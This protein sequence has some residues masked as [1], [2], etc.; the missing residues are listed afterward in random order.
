M[1]ISH[2]FNGTNVHI[3]PVFQ[4]CEQIRDPV[5]FIVVPLVYLLVFCVGLPGNIIALLV[6]MQKSKKIKKAIRIYLINLTLSDV[7]FNLTLPFWIVYYFN[8][9]DWIMSDWGCRIAGA[10]YYLATYSAIT[11]MMLISI[12]RYCTVQMVKIRLSL[13]K[14]KGAVLTCVFVWLCWSGCAIPSLTESQ[15]FQ[16]NM[17]TTKCFEQFSE[18]KNYAFATIAFFSLSFLV[19]F[20]TYVSIMRSL[21]SQN[22]QAQGAHRK[23]AKTMVLGMLLVFVI[24]VAPYHLSLA[25]WVQHRTAPIDCKPSNAVDI[26]HYLSIAL[27]SINSCIDPLIYCFSVKRF[28]ADLMKT[29]RKIFR[30]LLLQTGMSDTSEHGNRSTSFTSS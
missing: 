15:T 26:I 27:L 10:A 25:S 2:L 28:R 20:V 29:T 4:A 5:Q 9:G 19:V 7:L 6:F 17:S 8:G 30:C 18:H 21:S 3:T 16:T 24:C 1:N 14:Q 12:N 11:F 22:T 23:L 13:N